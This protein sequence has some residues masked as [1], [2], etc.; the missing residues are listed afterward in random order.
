M[1]DDRPFVH[2]VTWREFELLPAKARFADQLYASSWIKVVTVLGFGVV[3]VPIM[4][5]LALRGGRERRVPWAWGLYFLVSGISYMCVEIGLIAKT[6]LFL[7]NPLYT[8][9]VVLALFLAASGAGAYWQD[10][11]RL[12]Q[13]P[14]MI[15]PPAVAAIAWGVLGT[16]LCNAHLLGL[17]LPLKIVC[18]ALAIAPAGIFLGMVYPFGVGRLVQAGQRAAVPGTYAVATLSSVWGAA[19][20]M[21]AITNLGFSIVILLGAAGYAVTG[22]LYVIA[23]RAPA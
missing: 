1:T 8:T 2:E 17:P 19:W 6:E 9:A 22:L 10:R 5:L 11:L 16:H 13:R 12:F 4:A 14:T 7:G 3:A 18:A 15:V 23:R 21:T 20:A